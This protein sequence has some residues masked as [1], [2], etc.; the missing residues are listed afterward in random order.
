[1]SFTGQIVI[2][3]HERKVRV[4]QATV[5]LEDGGTLPVTIPIN[6][7]VQFALLPAENS[8][9]FWGRENLSV[10]DIVHPNDRCVP[11]VNSCI[12]QYSLRV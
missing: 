2:A 12:N 7:A 8:D 3:C 9:K 5:L 1:M 11:K 10:N 6:L 4:L